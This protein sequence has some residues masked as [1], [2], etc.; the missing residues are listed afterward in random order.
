MKLSL[1][2]LF[3]T[4]FATLHTISLIPF[5]IQRIQAIFLVSE[6]KFVI[7]FKFQQ[8][9]DSILDSTTSFSDINSS[10]FVT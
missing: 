9:F 1:K 7:Q 6:I 5:I 2:N 4:L 3:K 8:K 10:Q